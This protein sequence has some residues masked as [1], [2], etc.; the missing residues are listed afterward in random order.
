MRR[1]LASSVQFR[2]CLKSLEEV[3]PGGQ[4]IA[5]GKPGSG[6]RFRTLALIREHAR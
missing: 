3:S 1:L 6:N 2:V 4:G 5:H